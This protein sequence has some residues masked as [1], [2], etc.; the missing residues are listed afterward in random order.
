M[1]GPS[2]A[3]TKAGVSTVGLG[4]REAAFIEACYNADVARIESMMHESFVASVTDVNGRSALHF[5]AGN[6]LPTLCEKLM[7]KGATI[8]KQDVL[9]LT[10]L[11]MAAGYVKLDTVKLLVDRGADANIASFDGKLAVEIAEDMLEK[12]PQKKLFRANPAYQKLSD[13]VQVLDE[14]T[15]VEDDDEHEEMG[16]QHNGVTRSVNE[17]GDITE[18]TENAKFVVRVK[19]RGE[20]L[21]ANGANGVDDTTGVKVDDV[22]VTIKIKEA[23]KK[24]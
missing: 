4:E 13:M 5:C 12:T 1:Q 6:G 21:T 9:G 11:H 14:A 22:K 19:P 2:Q 7:D 15:E 16:Q 20:R 18:E 3:P 24:A 8:D 17:F 10:P 23:K